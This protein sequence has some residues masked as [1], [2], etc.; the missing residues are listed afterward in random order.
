VSKYPEKCIRTVCVVRPNG[1]R[2]YTTVKD[3]ATMPESHSFVDRSVPPIINPEVC[4]KYRAIEVG[5]EVK[6]G[7][8]AYFD[9]YG[10]V[11]FKARGTSYYRL[12][13]ISE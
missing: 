7:S 10:R 3:H 4:R 13:E 8:R 2:V 6:K 5:R 12:E 11:V 1:E 9:A